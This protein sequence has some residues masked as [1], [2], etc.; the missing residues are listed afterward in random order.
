MDALETARAAQPA[1]EKVPA[2]FMLDR[3]LYAR[4]AELGFSGIDFYVVGRGG[5]LGPVDADV[6]AAAFVFFHPDMI[7]REW[8]AGT[9]VLAAPEAA[10]AFSSHIRRWA[11]GCSDDVDW[12]R[13]AEL[14]G[15]VVQAAN[16]AVAP[17]FAGWRVLPEPP[18]EEAAALA[19]HRLNALRELQGARHGG[20]VLATG[21][22]PNDAMVVSDSN[23]PPAMF[24]WQDADLDVDAES[25]RPRWEQAEAATAVAMAEVY[26][27]LA[28]AERDELVELLSAAERA[29][30]G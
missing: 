18:A 15:P 14:V 1:I 13:L 8:E 19:V 11:T 5:V 3:E 23:M 29:V 27:P 9:A 28:P 10:K 17:L 4:G 12:A 26:A 20:A 30:A 16:P 6:V 2:R 25:V 24:G 7:R 22:R 21:L